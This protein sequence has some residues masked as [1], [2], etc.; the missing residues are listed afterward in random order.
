MCATYTVGT[1]SRL[2]YP[3]SGEDAEIRDS[4][5]WHTSWSLPV[6]CLSPAAKRWDAGS[7]ITTC[8][9]VRLRGTSPVSKSLPAGAPEWKAAR[10]QTFLEQAIMFN[11]FFSC[12][13]TMTRNTR[14]T[15]ATDRLA[16]APSYLSNR[17][18][19]CFFH[20]PSPLL[21]SVSTPPGFKPS[22]TRSGRVEQGRSNRRHAT[23]PSSAPP[24]QHKLF[25]SAG[26]ST[27]T[28]SG[29]SSSS[30]SSHDLDHCANGQASR[31]LS[32]VWV[33]HYIDSTM[34]QCQIFVTAET[35]LHCSWVY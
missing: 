7:C 9:A 35:K 11:I 18:A 6:P 32:R 4:S 28:S 20:H 10:N 15:D 3:P 21:N 13:P 24:P 22:K 5:L 19:R 25:H 2:K 17:L 26:R 30:G 12:S 29:N 31:V 34:H 8:P 33:F 14:R 1:R 27:S 23:W 16:A